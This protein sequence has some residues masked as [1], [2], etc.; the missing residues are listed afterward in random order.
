MVEPKRGGTKE[1]RVADLLVSLKA[2]RWKSIASAK[3]DDAAR[4]GLDK[5][6][7]EITLLKA[8]GGEIAGLLV[9][10]SEGPQT[11]VKLKTSPIVYAVDST[12]IRDLRKAPVEIPG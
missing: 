11:Y 5:P 3:G 4:F 2:L 12:L 7:L 10:R 6:E 8:D 9:G 1:R